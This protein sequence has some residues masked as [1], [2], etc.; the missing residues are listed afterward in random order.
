MS[1]EHYTPLQLTIPSDKL[2]ALAGVTQKLGSLYDLG[3]CQAGI[4]EYHMERS[5]CWYVTGDYSFPRTYRAP[6]WSWAS[7]DGEISFDRGLTYY[8][9][10]YRSAVI[11]LKATIEYAGLKMGPI[12]SGN[13]RLRGKM[14]RIVLD[15]SMRRTT[16]T[17][18][19]L[20]LNPHL[21]SYDSLLDRFLRRC[22]KA[23]NLPA[24]KSGSEDS[25]W[26]GI[27]WQIIDKSKPAPQ[28]LAKQ[29][30]SEPELMDRP[31]FFLPLLIHSQPTITYPVLVNP[32]GVAGLLLRPTTT[33]G[34]FQRV[35][36]LILSFREVPERSTAWRSYFPL[37]WRL[38]IFVL[39]L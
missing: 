32:H 23:L 2:V 33:R 25:G 17:G 9:Q 21:E 10:D 34:Q 30:E 3:S 15:K 39:D 11:D 13:I 37:G 22:E 24:V 12:I 31:L 38:I 35:G 6:S 1:I 8:L 36:Y 7:L 5:L 16:Y 4:W 18:G 20:F 26:Y 28:D 19:V 27:K 14:C 29:K